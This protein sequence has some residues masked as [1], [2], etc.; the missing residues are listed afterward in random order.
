M[1]QYKL[2]LGMLSTQ[3]NE[4]MNNCLKRKINN[5][6]RTNV[7]RIIAIVKDMIDEQ[8]HQVR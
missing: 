2:L 7:L 5:V 1:T 4:S 3:R 6:K 8:Y